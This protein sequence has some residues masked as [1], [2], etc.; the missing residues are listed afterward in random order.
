MF[1]VLL[2]CLDEFWYYSLFTL[3]MLVTFESTVV[4]QRIRSL[5]E[6]RALQTPKQHVQVRACCA[7]CDRLERFARAAELL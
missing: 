2:W 7:H 6:L 1:C 4:F 5:S 3:F